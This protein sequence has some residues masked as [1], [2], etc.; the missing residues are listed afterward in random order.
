M[1]VVAR[2]YSSTGKLVRKLSK[3]PTTAWSIPWN[4]RR[5][6]G[7]RVPDGRYKVVVTGTD[8]AGNTDKVTFYVRVSSKRMYWHSGSVT[9]SAGSFSDSYDGSYAYD[10][11]G[12]MAGITAS[13]RFD[14]GVT[15][16]ASDYEESWAYVGYR[17]RIPEA[18]AYEMTFRVLGAAKDDAY[19]A[20]LS[21]WNYSAEVD[22]VAKWA[23]SSYGW[24]TTHTDSSAHV[25]DGTVWAYL[26]AVSGTNYD[27]ATVKLTYRYGNLK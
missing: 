25:Q 23:N 1:Q 26:T 15:L 3:G 21:I 16:H 7:T 18:D 6:S 19:P 14:G 10:D 17:F 8:W 24:S 5:L 27:A 20:Y 11:Y 4:G 9:K 22:D 2:V 12:N 13:E